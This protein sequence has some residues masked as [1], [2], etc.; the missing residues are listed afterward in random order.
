V[1]IVNGLL[2]VLGRGARRTTG[3]GLQVVGR[4]QLLPIIVLDTGTCFVD[5]S[6]KGNRGEFESVT[7]F[8]MRLQQ[9][10]EACQE[11]TKESRRTRLFDG[12]RRHATREERGSV[13]PWTGR[14]GRRRAG[15]P[16]Q[17]NQLCHCHLGEGRDKSFCLL[18]RIV[19]TNSYFSSEEGE[20]TMRS[21]SAPFL[22]RWRTKTRIRATLFTVTHRLGVAKRVAR[23]ILQLVYVRI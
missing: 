1:Q 19:T 17:N 3:V 21:Q 23:N 8:Q 4:L 5:C 2:N 14:K 11:L 12:V 6:S 9:I 7:R 20:K 22:L 10:Y 16:Y 15:R 18:L 13:A